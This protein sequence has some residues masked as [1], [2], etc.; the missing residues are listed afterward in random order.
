[1]QNP[2][3]MQPCCAPWQSPDSGFAQRLLHIRTPCTTNAA[4]MAEIPDLQQRFADS[5]QDSQPAVSHRYFL[6]LR[7]ANFKASP[8]SYGWTREETK[9]VN[10]D[11]F[12]RDNW[13]N[14]DS[15]ANTPFENSDDFPTRKVDG[16]QISRF[17]E[18]TAFCYT[19]EAELR[20]WRFRLPHLLWGKSQRF[21]F[22]KTPIPF[23]VIERRAR[24]ARKE[25]RTKQ[26]ASKRREEGIV[27]ASIHR[28]PNESYT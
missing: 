18:T 4:P 28:K 21:W 5:R 14:M 26:D 17:R 13:I 19:D 20:P 6:I 11:R 8:S 10:D 1:M 16:F 3:H 22:R 23:E 12:H 9:V 2:A 24:Q 27:I 25:S 15:F 7:F